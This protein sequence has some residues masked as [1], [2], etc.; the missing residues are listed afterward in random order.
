MTRLS[1]LLPVRNGLPHL[2]AA[3][4]SVLQQSF[5]D[6]EMI[7]ID[8]GS[9]DGSGDVANKF[10]D[11]RIVV[12]RTECAG[13]AAALN[14]GLE[15]AS[16]EYVAR[17]DADDLSRVDRFAA[18]VDYLDA[19]RGVSL[20]SSLVRFID[21]D[22]HDVDNGWT[23]AVRSQWEQAIEP[24]E[25]AR[26]MPLTCCIV[27]GSVMARRSTIL[28]AGGYDHT[29]PV[30]QDY[31]LWLRML[32]RGKMARLRE[33]L[34]SFRIHAAQVSAT[35]GLEQA[36]QMIAAKLRYLRWKM[37]LRPDTTAEIIGGGNGARLYREALD[38]LGWRLDSSADLV[39]FTNFHTL[40]EDMTAFSATHARTGFARIGNFLVRQ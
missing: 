39:I 15:I 3:I 35:R 17:H 27:H 22:G 2:R 5:A 7:V 23:R 30:A 28:A 1:V 12:V 32:G 25:I 19:H 13:I 21:A 40:D 20:V 37:G 10:D 26:L 11:P 6:F 8:D 24:D 18:Q 14:R 34:Y 31:D 29:L 9:I 4:D 36:R 16:G 38:G 33:P